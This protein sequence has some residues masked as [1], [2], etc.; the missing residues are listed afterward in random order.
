MMRPGPPGALLAA[1]EIAEPFPPAPP[2]AL[3]QP[4]G[5]GDRN[6]IPLYA[7]PTAK[8][9][10]HFLPDMPL[11][12]SSMRSLGGYLNV[13][14][15]ESTVDDLAR[16]AGWDPVAFRLRHLTD[17]R[18]SA[19]VEA[20][21]QRFGWGRGAPRAGRGFAFARYKNLE[22]YCAVAVEITVDR[23]TGQVGIERVVAAVDTGE[24]VNPDGV[25]NQIEG[26]LLQA[27]SW[28]LFERVAFDRTRVASV[29]WSAYPILR[30]SAV[31]RSVEVHI[32]AQ[33]DQ[34]FLGVAEAAQGP[35][36]A[37]LANAIRDATGRRLRDLPLTAGKIK[38]ALGA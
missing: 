6:A 13:L 22:A 7:F 20:A 16:A 18:A 32:V 4:E 37:A 17:A 25:A 33:P 12:G 38:A 2:V 11:R 23:E 10:H 8:I 31:P 19:V 29:D 3:A 28:T 30:F 1:R 27:T 15:I 34:P 24:V 9:V 35:A 36:G 5:G 14:A 21:A 26:G